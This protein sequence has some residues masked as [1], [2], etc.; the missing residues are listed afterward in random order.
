MILDLLGLI[1][2][3]L[4]AVADIITGKNPRMALGCFLVSLGITL[5]VA[6]LMSL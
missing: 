2:D 5:A 3:V 6:L 4:F 1:W